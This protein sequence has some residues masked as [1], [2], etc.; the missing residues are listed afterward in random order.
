MTS[1]DTISHTCNQCTFPA[2]SLNFRTNLYYVQAL[3]TRG[4]ATVDPPSLFT[5]RIF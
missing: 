1:V 5:L 2:G 3:L 4:A